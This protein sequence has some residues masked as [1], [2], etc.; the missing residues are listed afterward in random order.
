MSTYESNQADYRR[1]E[2]DTYD[3]DH[4]PT[5]EFP[6]D[7]ERSPVDQNVKVI[8]DDHIHNLVKFLR[9]D[10]VLGMTYAWL[11]VAIVVLLGTAFVG[12]VIAKFFGNGP[13]VLWAW[14]API[15]L[16][17]MLVVDDWHN[18]I[19][20]AFTWLFNK[21]TNIRCDECDAAFK[22][23]LLYRCSNCEVSTTKEHY[24][25]WA[26][27]CESCGS[28]PD[29]ARCWRCGCLTRLHAGDEIRSVSVLYR[30]EK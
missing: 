7:V 12:W 27:K 17:V 6:D 15:P 21:G 11:C 14:L 28:R 24:S 10:D 5:H 9:Y 1:S 23:D 18:T 26:T 19:R 2:E 29:A 4:V 25:H 20:R 8:D 30:P 3:N 13:H 16:T 22:N